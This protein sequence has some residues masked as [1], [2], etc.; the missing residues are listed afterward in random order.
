MRGSLSRK[1]LLPNGAWLT[2]STQN[3]NYSRQATMIVPPDVREIEYVPAYYK[4]G[5]NEIQRLPGSNLERIGEGAFAWA[6]VR[7]FVAPPSLREIGIAA[8]INCRYLKSV[9]LGHTRKI[10]GLCF[11]GTQIELA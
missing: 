2:M 7:E 11:W 3:R 10:G 1:A 8:F 5:L 4:I 9:D 6:S